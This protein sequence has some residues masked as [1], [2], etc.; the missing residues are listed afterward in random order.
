MIRAGKAATVDRMNKGEVA[1]SQ[2]VREE[3][4]ERMPRKKPEAGIPRGLRRKCRT[5]AKSAFQYQIKIF[6]ISKN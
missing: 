3:K 2:V 4:K 1:D 6:V 5:K